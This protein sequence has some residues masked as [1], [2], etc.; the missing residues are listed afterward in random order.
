MLEVREDVVRVR[1]SLLGSVFAVIDDV[2]VLEADLLPQHCFLL[3]E[4]PPAAVQLDVGNAVL[5]SE[6][7]SC[8]AVASHYALSDIAETDFGGDEV[9]RLVLLLL[10]LVNERGF[11]E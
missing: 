8:E 3:I 1:S 2:D 10:D 5:R 4:M 7:F 6:F 11:P 9:A